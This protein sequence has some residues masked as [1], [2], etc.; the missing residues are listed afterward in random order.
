MGSRIRRAR[1][2]DASLIP[3]SNQVSLDLRLGSFQLQQGQGYMVQ[4]LA[5]WLC[6]ERDVQNADH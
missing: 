3:Q 2:E 6:M 4:T 5:F 1:L